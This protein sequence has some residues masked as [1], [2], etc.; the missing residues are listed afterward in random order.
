MNETKVPVV[1]AQSYAKLERLAQLVL[2]TLAPKCLRRPQAVP[3]AKIIEFDLADYCD[4]ELAVEDLP[5]GKMA[6]T[7]PVEKV[8]VLSSDVYEQLLA[9]VPRQR[10]TAAHEAGHAVVHGAQLTHCLENLSAISLARRSDIATYCDPEW[11]ANAFAA[12][13]LMPEPMVQ[14]LAHKFSGKGL[15][16]KMASTFKVSFECAGYRLNHLS[17]QSTE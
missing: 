17:P 4:F 14:K 13:I 7:D 5:G 16:E 10:F 12:S 11:Q 1:K 2:S 3:I 6:Y 8:I 15:K 9:D